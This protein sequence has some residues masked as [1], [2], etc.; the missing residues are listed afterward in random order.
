MIPIQKLTIKIT[1]K[2]NICELD[3]LFG[4]LLSFLFLLVI[5]NSLQKGK[6]RKTFDK[7]RENQYLKKEKAK[8]IIKG[9]TLKR[10]N[11]KI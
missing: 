1:S 4:S 2:M 9:D 3:S 5:F 10:I 6:F 7:I 11:L 8:H